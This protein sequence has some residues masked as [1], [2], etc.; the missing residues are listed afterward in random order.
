LEWVEGARLPLVEEA[1]LPAHVEAWFTRRE[2][3]R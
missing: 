1:L 3:A 2:S